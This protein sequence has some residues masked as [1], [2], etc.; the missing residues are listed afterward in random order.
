MHT[1][2]FCVRLGAVAVL[3]VATAAGFANAATKAHGGYHA[4]G[5]YKYHHNGQCVDARDRPP[6]AWADSMTSRPAW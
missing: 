5:E 1:F 3:M 2:M 4:C 6:A